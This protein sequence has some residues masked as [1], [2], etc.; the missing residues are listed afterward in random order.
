MAKRIRTN[1]E[2]QNITQK[3]KIEQHG[4]RNT[5][6]S[7][8]IHI[9]IKHTITKPNSYCYDV[10]D[11]L[12]SWHLLLRWNDLFIFFSSLF[13][14][15]QQTTV[16]WRLYF[17][18][19]TKVKSREYP[20]KSLLAEFMSANTTKKSIIQIVLSVSQRQSSSY[21]CKYNSS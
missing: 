10:N 3:L 20:K 11:F 17:I 14:L 13:I 7:N 19:D 8:I 1:S 9:L 16:T 5:T 15:S 21:L 2:L 12:I 6:N 18:V 4:N